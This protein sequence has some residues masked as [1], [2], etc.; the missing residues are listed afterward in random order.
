MLRPRASLET[1]MKPGSPVDEFIVGQFHPLQALSVES[2]KTE[3]VQRPPRAGGRTA[4]FPSGNRP[5]QSC[6]SIA[7]RCSGVIPRWSQTKGSSFFSFPEERCGFLAQDGTDLL[8][9]G[10]EIFHLCRL[11]EDGIHLHADRH[12]LL[13]PVVENSPF[14]HQRDDPLGLPFGH[15]GKL[16]ALENLQVVRPPE[17]DEKQTTTQGRG[18]GR[19]GGGAMF[20]RF[21]SS[22]DDQLFLLGRS[23]PEIPGGHSLD[24][25]GGLEGRQ[26]QPQSLIFLEKLLLFPGRLGHLVPE[27]DNLM[28]RPDVRREHPMK[29][30]ATI[31]ATK[32]RLRSTPLRGGL[33]PCPGHR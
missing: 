2:G 13:F 23:Q 3:D 16:F 30:K 29:T 32:M 31:T 28:M 10:P 22:H 12:F 4:S 8:G 21:E 14:G 17:N 1:S 20:D 18:G 33:L 25:G 26:I 15:A 9:G 6:F 19:C 27:G 11:G 7:V 5:R 24:P